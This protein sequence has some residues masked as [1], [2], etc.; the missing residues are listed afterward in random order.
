MIRVLGT[1]FS[2][3]K[4]AAPS[5]FTSKL[6]IT[7]LYAIN[8]TLQ[9]V[10]LKVIGA[11]FS[12]HKP[13]QGDAEAFTTNLAQCAEVLT[14]VELGFV[15]IGVII[16]SP[17]PLLNDCHDQSCPTVS[18][19]IVERTGATAVV[20][21]ITFELSDT[22]RAASLA[23]I[24]RLYVVAAFRPE[25]VALPV[26]S[27]VR[28][29]LTTPFAASFATKLVTGVV[30]SSVADRSKFAELKVG[31]PTTDAE[32][33]TGFVVSVLPPPLH[34]AANGTV[35]LFVI[36]CPGQAG[37]LH[38]TCNSIFAGGVGYVN[39][40]LYSDN[41]VPSLVPTATEGKPVGRTNK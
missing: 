16:G 5:N 36:H 41:T 35:N 40:A 7:L 29:L 39:V 20:N 26:A 28:A 14:P 17:S 30:T 4:P 1:S 12:D 31:V 21:V 25:I 11:V 15:T 34:F 33:I 13:A 9:F 3:F 38:N 27:A 23:V 2:K 19:S 37:L 6:L 22:L 10:E 32:T 18:K 24:V 8:F